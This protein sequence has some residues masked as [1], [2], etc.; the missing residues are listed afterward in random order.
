MKKPPEPEG[1]SDFFNLSKHHANPR[2]QIGDRL[3]SLGNRKR[4]PDVRSALIVVSGYPAGMATVTFDVSHNCRTPNREQREYDVKQWNCPDC[5]DL[6]VW[7]TRD[8][9]AADEESPGTYRDIW[10]WERLEP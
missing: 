9:D 5:G 1:P 7:A 10:Q 4:T 2:R 3:G 8:D 6:W